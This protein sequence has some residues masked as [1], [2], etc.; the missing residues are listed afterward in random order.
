M[1]FRNEA[2]SNLLPSG[3]LR[4]PLQV[5]PGR[6]WWLCTLGCIGL[7]R[8]YVEDILLMDVIHCHASTDMFSTPHSCHWTVL[9]RQCKGCLSILF[10]L[11]F[12]YGTWVETFVLV[13]GLPFFNN[14]GIDLREVS[15]CRSWLSSALRTRPASQFVL[16]H[17][18]KLVISKLR[19]TVRGIMPGSHTDHRLDEVC[20]DMP[21]YTVRENGGIICY[22][23]FK[24]VNIQAILPFFFPSNTF[25]PWRNVVIG[26]QGMLENRQKWHMNSSQVLSA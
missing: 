17:V 10:H 24:A 19:C 9:L 25:A 6:H 4:F 1:Y 18:N 12:C 26:K 8:W 5:W 14:Q 22:F 2:W 15:W 21:F 7:C 11:K 13:S 16:L 23:I 20:R 3:V